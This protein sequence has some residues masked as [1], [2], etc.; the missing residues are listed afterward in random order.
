MQFPGKLKS[1]KYVKTL[2]DSG[3]AMRKVNNLFIETEINTLRD[4]VAMINT[5]NELLKKKKR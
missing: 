1:K 4:I 3:E 5:I 2:Q